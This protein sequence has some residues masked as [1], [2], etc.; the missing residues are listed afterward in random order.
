MRH[1]AAYDD[2]PEKAHSS[3]G[4]PDSRSVNVQCIV[5]MRE[6]ESRYPRFPMNRPKT[7]DGEK[8]ICKRFSGLLFSITLQPRLVSRQHRAFAVCVW[9]LFLSFGKVFAEW[10]FRR[11]CRVVAHISQRLRCLHLPTLDH[12]VREVSCRSSYF[13]VSTGDT[14]CEK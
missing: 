8:S 5:Y 13:T 6:T 9:K 2:C 12:P 11:T 7:P 14:G 4:W 1:K 3:S 10:L